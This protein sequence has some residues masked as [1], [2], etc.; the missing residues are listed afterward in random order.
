MNTTTLP[1]LNSCPPAAFVEALQG[2][3]E[4]SPWI[5]DRAAAMRPFASVAA[6]K[7]A[8][9]AVVQQASNDE[10]LALL[11]AHPE[12]AG[13]AA[14]AGELTAESTGEQA[15]S[16]LDRCSLDEYG[17]LQQLNKDY[18]DK[19]GFPFILAVKGPTGRGLTR[20]AIIATFA[21]RLE[22]SLD[23]EMAE[24]LRQVHRIAEIRLN[25]LLGV[26]LRF[27]P[28]VMDWAE[29]LGAISDG[30]D[31]LTCAY[32]TPSHIRTAARLADWMREA[33]MTVHIDAVGNVIGRYAA[34]QPDARVW[35]T[36]SHYDTV[37]NGGKYDGRLGILLPIAL[38]RHLHERGERLP[39]HLDVVGFAEEEGVRFR[40]T[41]LGSSA[42]T[43]RFDAALLEQRDGDG[44][45][46]RSALAAAG[47]DPS[48]IPAIARDPASLLG[49]VE[50]HIEQGPVLLERGL[51]V[52]VVT[53]I[54]GSSRY[55]VELMGVAGH[56]GTTPM[57]MRRDAA[58]AAAEIVLL[59][60][61]RCGGRGSL[62]G[63]VGQLEVPSG[64]VNV[65]PG[66]CRLSLDIRAASDAE[67]LAAVDDILA[68]IG[69]ICARRGVKEQLW[70]LVEAD[71]APCSPRLMDMLGD[72]LLD[73]GLPRFDLLSGAG[74]DAMEMARITE[75][76][77]LFTRCGNGGI[78][79]NPLETM[80]ADDAEVAGE[81]LLGFLRRLSY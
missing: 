48:S 16:G 2:V 6:L 19:F 65:I 5:A 66:R 76:A 41:F 45:T 18:G 36:G 27:G 64:S 43:G 14:I 4:H 54:A 38:V 55:L 34:A 42:I 69:A 11:R 24:C 57:D 39:F 12:L 1:H 23:A 30:G 31:G 68:G 37:R 77:M 47:H 21:R 71:A 17:Q 51:P 26:A 52:G 61:E 13:K 58:A 10:R 70:K 29:T 7:Q 75:V 53:A 49:F 33:G 67:R 50:V 20:A 9:Q 81:V 72:A 46:M 15:A 28:Q 22:N 78:S 74:H 40:S 63:T 56:A 62:V 80:T 25:A 60:E 35:M 59:V 8:L 44:V 32:M 3:Y 79:H 73:S